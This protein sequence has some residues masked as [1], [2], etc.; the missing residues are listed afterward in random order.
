MAE[1]DKVL[2]AK[3]EQLEAELGNLRQKIQANGDNTNFPGAV[4]DSLGVGCAIVEVVEDGD[5]LDFI[6]RHY[7][8]FA[9]SLDNFRPDQLVGQSIYQL[10]PD[11]LKRYN[12]IGALEAA[13]RTGEVQRFPVVSYEIEDKTVWRENIFSRSADEKHVIVTF[14]DVTPQKNLEKALHL[15][16]SRLK[17]VTDNMTDMIIAMDIEMNLTFASPSHEKILG[18]KPEEIVGTNTTSRIHVEDVQLFT[19]A[20]AKCA[21]SNESVKTELRIQHENGHYLWVETIVN[22]VLSK[23]GNCCGFVVTGREI[24]V[25]K[26]AENELRQSEAKFRGLVESSSDWIWEVDIKGVYKYCSSQVENILGFS[27]DEVVGKSVFDFLAPDEV[28]RIG[29]VFRNAAENKTSTSALEKNVLHKDGHLVTVETSGIVITDATGELTGFR[30]VNRDIT[31]RKEAEMVR[32][33]QIQYLES[34]E[35]IDQVIKSSTDPDLMLQNVIETVYKLYDCDRAWLL[36]PCNPNEPFCRIPIESCRPE[37]PGARVLDLNIP[38]TSVI[39]SEMTLALNSDGPI[40]FGPGNDR[41]MSEETGAAFQIM[42]QICLRIQPKTGQAWMFGIHQ[43]SHERIF[44]DFERRLFNEIGRRIEDSLSSLLF[45]HILGDSEKKF[46]TMFESSLDAILLLDPRTGYIDCN[47]AAQKMFA[48]DSKEK[49]CSLSLEDLA[50]EFQP[51]GA[52]S[53][54]SGEEVI[55][56]TINRGTSYFTWQSRGIDGREF[57]STVLANRIELDDEIILQVIIRDNTRQKEAEKEMLALERQVQHSNKLK[58]L[59]V[60][61]GGIAHD[62]NNLLMVIL[63]NAD[64]ALGE[65][66]LSSSAHN[67]LTEIRKASQRAAELAKQMLAYSGRGKFHIVPNDA[68]TIIKEISQLLEATTPKKILLKFD[69]AEETPE[70]DGDATQIRQVIMNLI[71]NAAEAI[72]DEY[73]TISLSTGG[74]VCNRAYL[75]DINEVLRAGLDEP[76]CE[77]KYSYFE[78]SDTGCGIDEDSIKKIF[79]PFFTTKF[80]GRGLGLSAV[81]GIVRGH[82][83]ALKIS[84]Q[85]AKGTIFRVLFPANEPCQEAE[86]LQLKDEAIEPDRKYN[87][88]VLIVDDE[89]TVCA[90]GKQM[91]KR[92]GFNVLTAFDGHEALTLFHQHADDIVCVLLDLTMPHMDGEEA[93]LEMRKLDPEV[94]V[95]LCSGYNMQDATQRFIGKGLAGFIQ[96]PYNRTQLKAVLG[97]VLQRNSTASHIDGND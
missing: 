56:E 53:Q 37:Y 39:Q 16:E 41:P 85:L 24:T 36:Y 34:L 14:L 38:T 61:A 26:Q 54:S 15:T 2:S 69:F 67:N 93:F 19:D 87:G 17:Q 12:F 89:A 86:P 6:Y 60:L 35:Q 32:L 74:M 81:L 40:T 44:T 82:K 4:F 66:A 94:T 84:S 29:A 80:T 21:E 47:A 83:G 48:A 97:E 27:P 77:G 31:I 73:G 28:D 46:R 92:L 78:I 95:I 9:C 51:D 7:N 70:F 57:P 64:L 1:N 23:E 20:L 91:L 63:G 90:V 3:I 59:G 18:V 55:A 68:R 5:R 62:F 75:D 76:L 96:K 43:C 88:T 8:E 30:G 13:Y 65:L 45:F 49:L 71:I 79:D 10:F 11:A 42:S 72:G 50:P 52:P 58:S 33:E 22:T 25:R